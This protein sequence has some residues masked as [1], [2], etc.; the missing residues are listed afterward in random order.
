MLKT[1]LKSLFIVVLFIPLISIGSDSNTKTIHLNPKLQFKALT[2]PQEY[3]ISGLVYGMEMDDKGQ[4]WTATFTGLLK[5]VGSNTVAVE[6]ISER[7]DNKI[8]GSL[9]VQGDY[10]WS[11]SSG[12]LGRLHLPTGT[13][14]L[15]G[16]DPSVTDGSDVLLKDRAVS[17]LVDTDNILW[18]GQMYGLSKYSAATQTFE[19]IPL[20]IEDNEEG[21]LH[22]FRTLFQN[23]AGTVWAGTYSHGLI[24]LNTKSS[25]LEL[26]DVYKDIK[27][28][29]ILS[30]QGH[31]ED[32]SKLLVGADTGLYLFDTTQDTFEQFPANS[33]ITQ[34]IENISVSLAG[35]VWVTTAKGLYSINKEEII[36]QYGLEK[37]FGIDQDN[38]VFRYVYVDEQG[39]IFVSIRNVG[40]FKASNSTS[41][42]L[43]LS[44]VFE[45]KEQVSAIRRDSNGNIWVGFDK[46]VAKII[47]TEGEL[48]STEIKFKNERPIQNIKIIKPAT[49]GNVLL[50]TESDIVRINT[51]NNEII[52]QHSFK[53]KVPPGS[54]IFSLTEDHKGRVWIYFQFHGIFIFDPKMEALEKLD[55]NEKFKD[56]YKVF[57]ASSPDFTRILIGNQIQ[58][59]EVDASSLKKTG[60]IINSYKEFTNKIKHKYNIDNDEDI[61]VYDIYSEA[62][63]EIKLYTRDNMLFHFR[64]S[65]LCFLET[66][67]DISSYVLNYSAQADGEWVTDEYSKLYFKENGQKPVKVRASD[68]L[69]QTGLLRIQNVRLDDYTALFGSQEG[70]ILA[71]TRRLTTNTYRPKT[72]VES[73][74]FQAGPENKN[75]NARYIDAV[76]LPAEQRD[77]KITL[78]STN[79]ATSQNVVYRY[80]LKGYTDVWQENGSGSIWFTNM[81][82]GSYELEFVSSNND[83][84]FGEPVSFS[85]KVLPAWYESNFAYLCYLIIFILLYIFSYYLAGIA[86]RK[87]ED[88]LQ[89]LIDRATQNLLTSNK[90]L[91]KAQKL[92][93]QNYSFTAHSLR[94]PLSILDGMVDHLR[95]DEKTDKAFGSVSLTLNEMSRKVDYILLSGELENQELVGGRQDKINFSELVNQILERYTFK[96][97]KSGLP[98]SWDIESNIGVIGDADHLGEIPLNLLNNALKY[99][100]AGGSVFLTLKKEGSSLV[101]SV[102]DEG[103][104]IP[105]DK[106]KLIGRRWAKQLLDDVNANTYSSGL[107]MSAVNDILNRNNGTLSVS[108]EVGVGS[109]FTVRLPAI[110]ADETFNKTRVSSHYINREFLHAEFI[111]E[112]KD[113]TQTVYSAPGS[114]K[115]DIPYLLIVEDE[116]RQASLYKSALSSLTE[117]QIVVARTGVEALKHAEQFCPNII[118]SDVMMPEMTGAELVKAVR[119]NPLI[120]HTPIILI[121]GNDSEEVKYEALEFSANEFLLK[122]VKSKE[123]RYR[124]INMLMQ[125]KAYSESL[126]DSKNREETTSPLE[127]KAFELIE[128]TEAWIKETIADSK[129]PQV[130]ELAI[131]IAEKL[132]YKVK[133]ANINSYFNS[134]IGKDPSTFIKEYR[135][136]MAK[137]LLVNSSLSIAQVAVEICYSSQSALTT[138]FKNAFNMTPDRYRKAQLSEKT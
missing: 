137:E 72:Y 111:E 94:Q 75:L 87:R 64:W 37:D 100:K 70:L 28:R 136:K 96:F 80:R 73:I 126:S 60:N 26:F 15:Y 24:K 113:L 41:K 134:L 67:L 21:A 66:R 78:Q 42:L 97:K 124:V 6:A 5:T 7:I 81:S 115:G 20:K 30:I 27:I 106:V 79:S 46:G 33:P 98:L 53:D 22:L 138:D 114:I 40:L 51:S 48:Y 86:G 65:C 62:A 90:K 83:G 107:G 103:F 38:A 116:P 47:Q 16:N 8:H 110:K 63:G 23:T 59:W 128:F 112:S 108:S 69:P 123:L 10:L 135:L 12:E 125:I 88:K 49:N 14:S 61:N 13:V 39:T 55:I 89:G 132:L 68:G 92:A 91:T 2:M 17:L 84:L 25:A 31:P 120:A 122:P 131:F 99:S 133:P 93:K 109:T 119:S 4:L 43:R 57:L 76:V 19:S 45:N 54:D 50:A 102:E 95:I 118:V 56:K 1:F 35:E 44:G 36:T 29:K 32:E 85:I 129:T 9:V 3:D 71:D 74:E 11:G 105:K 121:T 130:G 104:G 58:F 127:K 18:I 52:Y 34:P 77:I 101:L 82:K 117:Y